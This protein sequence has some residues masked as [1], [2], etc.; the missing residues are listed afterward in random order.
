MRS[1]RRWN[2]ETISPDRAIWFFD[3]ENV[4]DMDLEL[5]DMSNVEDATAM[6][7]GC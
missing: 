3:M 7:G 6:F 5:L 1:T 4:V 2:R